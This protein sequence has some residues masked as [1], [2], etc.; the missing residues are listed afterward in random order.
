[1]S[2]CTTVAVGAVV[3]FALICAMIAPTAVLTVRRIVV[4]ALVVFLSGVGRGVGLGSGGIV[5]SQ[6]ESQPQ[7]CALCQ[8]DC[9][10]NSLTYEIDAL[11]EFCRWGSGVSLLASHIRLLV[12]LS[13][14]RLGRLVL[15]EEAT[16]MSVVWVQ[17]N[18]TGTGGARILQDQ[19]GWDGYDRDW[20]DKL[21]GGVLIQP[22]RSIRVH[23]SVSKIF[24]PNSKYA[25]AASVYPIEEFILNH[26][27]KDSKTNF[28]IRS[29][30]QIL[31][32]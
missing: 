29:A 24:P 30:R 20:W 12:G 27:S 13:G 26:C 3:G 1:M 11:M 17:P 19:A 6:V 7:A 8:A 10:S 9:L 5:I 22:S 14:D 21:G 4:N 23:A 25:F 16:G 2:R 32:S 15:V 18:G 28:S 31:E